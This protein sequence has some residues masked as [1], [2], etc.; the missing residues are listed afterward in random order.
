[1][2]HWVGQS[3]TAWRRGILYVCGHTGNVESAVPRLP[4]DPKLL[5][6]VGA[7]LLAAAVALFPF[8]TAQKLRWRK[9]SPSVSQPFAPRIIG[10]QTTM[11]AREVKRKVYPYS[12]IPGGAQDLSQAK[13]YMSDPAV[14]YHY[15]GV[16]L[17]RLREVKLTAPLT[18]YVSYRWGEKI[19]WTSKKL[20][21]KA[22]ETV[23][24]DGT[25]IVRGRCLNCYSALPMQPI[26]PHE[27]TELALDSPVEMPET[28]YSFPK[29]PLI[30]AEIPIPPGELTPTVPVFPAAPPAGPP[31]AGKRPGGGFWFP[32]IPII[33]PI[34]HRHP[35]QPPSGPPS[36]PGTPLVP[37][38]VAVV[39]EPRYEWALGIGLLM[40]VA[41]DRL[42][43]RTRSKRLRDN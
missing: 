31:I 23:F 3:L 8:H 34:H 4:L 36:G 22:G 17:S 18:G 5:L 1:M 30:A 29:L 16:D 25:H 32:I 15:A 43:R 28:V 21:L 2:L 19:Y 9:P 10:Y 37:P 40:I 11:V 20:T 35:P 39:P 26:R 13:H 14:K 24:T 42:R 27:P 7:A 33:P 6:G 38:P 12:I 41:A